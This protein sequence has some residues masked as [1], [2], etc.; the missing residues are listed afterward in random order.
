MKNTSIQFE[1]GLVC[2]AVSLL[3]ACGGGGTGVVTSQTPSPVAMTNVTTTVMDGLIENALVCVDTN[4]NGLCELSETQGRTNAVG[5][6]TLAISGAELATAHLV[7]LIGLDA[8][9]ADT[10]PINGTIA[11]LRAGTTT[12][13]GGIKWATEQTLDLNNL[14]IILSFYMDTGRATGCWSA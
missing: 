11:Q 14:M 5:Q 3:S 9:D 1:L 2:L 4:S 13:K 12:N 7:A 8:V 6:V 10:G